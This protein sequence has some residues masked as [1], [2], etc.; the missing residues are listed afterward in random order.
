[1][2]SNQAARAYSRS[3]KARQYFRKYRDPVLPAFLVNIYVTSS[4]D[5]ISAVRDLRLKR[6]F[7]DRGYNATI[8]FLKSKKRPKMRMEIL[9]SDEAAL[10]SLEK[11]TELETYL[12][13]QLEQISQQPVDIRLVL[14]GVEF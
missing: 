14:R 13:T 11:D 6:T 2:Q 5:Q 10:D 1:M 4:E 7:W 12:K 9:S 3:A 8:Q